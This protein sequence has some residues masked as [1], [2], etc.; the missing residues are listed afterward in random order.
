MIHSEKMV[1]PVQRYLHNTRVF[2]V[3]LCGRKLSDHLPDMKGIFS[4][5]RTVTRV[6]KMR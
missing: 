3:L 1:T 4:D 2:H 5:L 6:T